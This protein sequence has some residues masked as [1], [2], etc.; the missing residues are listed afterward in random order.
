MTFGFYLP[1]PCV[2]PKRF[3]A[4]TILRG[5]CEARAWQN[6]SK[7]RRHQRAAAPRPHV[8]RVTAD[9]RAVRIA[10]ARRPRRRN[11]RGKCRLRPPGTAHRDSAA[12]PTKAEVTM[13]CVPS[14]CIGCVS[15]SSSRLLMQMSDDLDLR[16]APQPSQR[17]VRRSQKTT[18]GT[19]RTHRSPHQT[20]NLGL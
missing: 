12:S 18:H 4:G 16:I 11:D 20:I 15:C 9:H 3:A 5:C 6:T 17:S 19:H 1:V 8:Q 7:C 14:V 10:H 2:T 13:A